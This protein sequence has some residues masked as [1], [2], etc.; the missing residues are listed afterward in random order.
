[1]RLAQV[2]SKSNL[3]VLYIH[4]RLAVNGVL[5]DIL[6]KGGASLTEINLLYF[7]EPKQEIIKRGKSMLLMHSGYLRA[8]RSGVRIPAGA[9]GLLLSKKEKSRLAPGPTLRP[10]G[11]GVFRLQ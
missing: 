5:K 3:P 8:G 11:T 10:M 1:M 6:G 7:G 2:A 9:R 4:D